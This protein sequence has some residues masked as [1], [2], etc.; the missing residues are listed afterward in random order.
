MI[1]HGDFLHIP[2]TPEDAPSHSSAH[3]VDSYMLKFAARLTGEKRPP[4][5]SQA[6]PESE[7]RPL[8]ACAFASTTRLWARGA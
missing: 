7:V 5:A 6:G 2:G 8:V 4:V 1:D 3:T